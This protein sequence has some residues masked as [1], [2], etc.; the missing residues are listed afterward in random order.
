MASGLKPKSYCDQCER[1]YNKEWKDRNRE[2][3]RKAGR[4][5]ARRNPEKRRAWRIQNAARNRELVQRG[6]IKKYGLSV[7]AYH[8]MAAAQDYRCAICGKH[9]KDILHGRLHVDHDH[10]TNQVRALLCDLCNAGIGRFHDDA[11]L[12]L[13]AYAYLAKHKTTEAAS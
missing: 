9:A 3:T 13:K 1:E 8:A 5:Y 2:K 4:E 12:L 11:G 6:A 10:A 7:E